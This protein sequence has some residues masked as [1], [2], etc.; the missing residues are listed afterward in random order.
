MLLSEFCIQMVQGWLQ[1]VVFTNNP[2]ENIEKGAG[3]EE[4]PDWF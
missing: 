2:L 3:S 1:E 4:N